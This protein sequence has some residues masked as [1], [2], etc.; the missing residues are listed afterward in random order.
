MKHIVTIVLLLLLLLAIPSFLVGFIV[1]I[2][3][4]FFRRGNAVADDCLE[5]FSKYCE[6]FKK[7]KP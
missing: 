2:P 1:G 6:K 5:G 7:R 3:F 4:N